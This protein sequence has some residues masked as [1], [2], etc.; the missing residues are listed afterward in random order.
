VLGMYKAEAIG[1]FRPALLAM[2]HLHSVDHHMRRDTI[3]VCK[4]EI[5]HD[6]ATLTK[7][8]S[9]LNARVLHFFGFL[10]LLFFCD[11]MRASLHARRRLAP[12]PGPR[13]FASVL[14]V[15]CALV[16]YAR[17]V[18]SPPTPV[19]CARCLSTRARANARSSPL[20]QSWPGRTRATA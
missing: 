6:L 2:S 9:L 14:R 5:R 18:R 12:L 4:G 11:S 20:L 16:V 13:S 17:R 1:N 10:F 15:I 3:R 7:C 8:A 19:V